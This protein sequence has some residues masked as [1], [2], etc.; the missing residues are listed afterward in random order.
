VLREVAEPCAAG[1]LAADEREADRLHVKYT[2]APKH[3]IENDQLALHFRFGKHA[4]E[5]RGTGC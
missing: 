2:A 4:M 3:N 5:G 1:P